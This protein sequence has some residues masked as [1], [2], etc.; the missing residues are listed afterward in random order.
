MTSQLTLGPAE[1]DVAGR[2]HEPVAVH[3]ALSVVREHAFPRI[4]LQDRGARLL[5]LENERIPF[6]GHQQ[7][8]PAGGADAP[9]ANDFGCGILDFVAVEQ[10][11]LGR[12]E[13]FAVPFEGVPDDRMDLPR[14]V[15]F[16]V[17]DRRELVLENRRP[18][19]I[20]YELRE[21]AFRSA[22]L[23]RLGQVLDRATAD[24]GI[25][26][27]GDQ[28][29]GLNGEVPQIQHLHFGELGHVLP[30]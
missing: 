14:S 11:A 19:R 6:V 1:E 9:D 18:A 15:I 24:P 13:G 16:P 26:D 30:V 8:H 21:E 4:C 25:L 27:A 12:R 7:H 23:T 29:L 3:H 28:H 22:A 10:H 5:D 2:L 17:E 20:A